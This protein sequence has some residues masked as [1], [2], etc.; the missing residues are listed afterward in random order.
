[1]S[2]DRK[3]RLPDAAVAAWRA[4][5][6]RTMP[7]TWSLGRGE[8]HGVAGVDPQEPGAGA[9]GGGKDDVLRAVAAHQ[10][11]GNGGQQGYRAVHGVQLPG[12]HAA[13]GGR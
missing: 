12:P 7:G 8:E 13:V 10:F 11:G 9:V 3:G 5:S 4:A 2:A 6:N 1:M